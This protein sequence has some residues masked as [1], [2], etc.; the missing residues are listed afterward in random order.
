MGAKILFLGE[1]VGKSGVFAVKSCLPELK[2]L[3][4]PDFIAANADSATGG[5]GLGVQHAVY[6]R[7][8]GVDC[9]TL[10]ESSYYKLDLMDFYPKAPWI[11]RPANLPYDNPGRG[12]RIYPSPAGKVGVLTL[13]GQAGFS[14]IHGENPFHAFDYIVEKMR[15][16]TKTILLDFHASTTAEE[17]TMAA[18]ADGRVTAVV[19]SHTKVLSADERIMSK[20]TAAISAS[21]RTGSILSVGGMNPEGRIK[22][23]M[24]ATRV[25]ESDSDQGLEVQGIFLET[26]EE[27]KAL[28][29]ERFRFPCKEMPHERV[30]NSQEY[31]R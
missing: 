28:R 16:E 21:G 17:L 22:E 29:I 2:A 8:L 27:G 31:R 10:G 9:L 14:R 1:I 26:G 11:L 12:W 5:A 19:G 25:W 23:F 7:K 6:L 20:G 13:L 3:Y 18:Y 30:G 24:T 4:K 15:Q